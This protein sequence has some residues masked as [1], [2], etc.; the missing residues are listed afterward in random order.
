MLLTILPHLMHT[1]VLKLLREV[2][3]GYDE[4]IFRLLRNFKKV[5]LVSY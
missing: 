3:G 2:V 1:L 4:L 5:G